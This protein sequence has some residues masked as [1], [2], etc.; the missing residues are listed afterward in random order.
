VR[1]EEICSTLVDHVRPL[2]DKKNLSLTLQIDDQ[3]PAVFTDRGKL[4]QILFNY[5]SNAIKFTPEEGQVWMGVRR[6]DETHVRVSVRDTGP[7]IAPEHHDTI[8]EKFRQIDQSAT[9]EHH[10][11]GLGLAIAKELAYLLGGEVGVESE[12]GH[13]ATFWLALPTTAPEPRER[14]PVSLV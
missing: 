1:V 8:F 14:H 7:G 13:G 2:A 6:L 9:R 10:G 3:I 11:T 4:R 12:P 5:L